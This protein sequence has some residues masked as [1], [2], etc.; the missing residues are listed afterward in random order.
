VQPI[1][2]LVRWVENWAP[3][4]PQGTA[5]ALDAGHRAAVDRSG[6]SATAALADA[7]TATAWQRGRLAFDDEPLRSAVEIVNRYSPKRIVIEDPGIEGLRV[8]GTV[9]EDHIDGWVASLETAFGIRATED[10]QTIRLQR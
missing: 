2:E 5:T 3:D 9:M 1:R 10:N 6:L 4:F 8:S 7:S